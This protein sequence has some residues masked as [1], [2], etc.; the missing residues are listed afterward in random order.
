MLKYK[1]CHTLPQGGLDIGLKVGILAEI[2]YMLQ[3]CAV[4]ER[5]VNFGTNQIPNTY[6][7]VRIERTEYRVITRSKKTIRVVFEYLKLFE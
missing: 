3:E 4:L 6:L 2:G 7:I 5:I 1:A